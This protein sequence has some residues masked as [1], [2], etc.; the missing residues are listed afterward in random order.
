MPEQSKGGANEVLSLVHALQ[1]ATTNAAIKRRPEYF[2]KI[3]NLLLYNF[4]R[5][6]RPAHIQANQVYTGGNIFYIVIF[7]NATGFQQFA[8]GQV[9][10][11]FAIQAI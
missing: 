7:I 9:F 4:L 5:N 2:L 8:V 6:K 10:Y 3:S 11:Q 1:K